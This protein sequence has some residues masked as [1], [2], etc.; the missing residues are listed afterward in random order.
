MSRSS[1]LLLAF[2]GSLAFLS[3]GCINVRGVMYV[4]KRKVNDFLTDRKPDQAG[5]P[6]TPKRLEY[7]RQVPDGE[8]ILGGFCSDPEIS[9]GL[10]SLRSRQAECITKV[11][12]FSDR[13]RTNAIVHY[14]LLSSTAVLGS[15]MIVFGVAIPEKGVAAGLAVGFGAGALVSALVDSFGS[16]DSR[17]WQNKTAAERLDNYL[18]TMR[19]R[20]SVEVCNAPDLQ[21]ARVRM[22][23]IVRNFQ[24][25]CSPKYEDD[26]TYPP[27]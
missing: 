1:V 5:L 25:T 21:I 20:V 14:S 27:N 18:W 6:S 16:F 22:R 26:G 13:A 23:Q 15:L 11:D 19:V 3:S 8:R 7:L 17:F 4:G 9:D 2:L 12:G 10:K 24:S